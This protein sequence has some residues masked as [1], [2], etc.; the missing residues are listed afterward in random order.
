[1]IKEK[2]YTVQELEEQADELARQSSLNTSGR[3]VLCKIKSGQ[4]PNLEGTLLAT[5]LEQIYYLIDSVERV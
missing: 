1:M 2:I 5:K 4:Y 3:D